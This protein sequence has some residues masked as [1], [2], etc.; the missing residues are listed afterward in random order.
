MKAMSPEKRRFFIASMFI[1]TLQMAMFAPTPG[2]Q[3][4]KT[5]KFTDRSLADIQAAMM[6]PSVVA[7]FASILSSALIARRILSK[8]A[9]VVI[10][11]ALM[12][13]TAVAALVLHTSFWQ[14]K[15]FSVL[16]G[17][18]MG[19]LVGPLSSVMFDQ[20]NEE[21]R[22]LSMGI[23]SAFINGGAIV[24]SV[25]GGLLAQAV[26]YGGYLMLLLAVPLVFVAVKYVPRDKPME[27]PSEGAPRKKWNLPAAVF[28]YGVAAMLN[29]LINH[30]NGTNISTHLDNARLGN[31]AT[32][33]VATAIQMAGGVVMGLFFSRISAKLKDYTMPLAFVLYA[34]G[35]TL[36]SVGTFSLI[37]VFIGVFIAGMSMSLLVPQVLFGTSN[38]VSTENSATAVAIVNSVL[39]GIGGYLSPIVFTNITEAIRPGSTVFRF[40]FVAGVALVVAAGLALAAS[41]RQKR[42]R[43]AQPGA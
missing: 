39:P 30:V 1:S 37:V 27:P 36:I 7:L 25:G 13:L 6:L 22:R 26:W 12:G 15:L 42:S 14:L 43:R 35:Y 2:I 8:K 4:I 32:A 5:Q 24:L 19:F 31:T 10:G 18:G 28:F 23:Q 38:C 3:K 17:V 11:T 20:F 29:A 33:G 41:V 16:I 9:C 21:E 40:Q 34:V